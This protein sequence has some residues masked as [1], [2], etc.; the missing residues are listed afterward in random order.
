[1]DCLDID[2]GYRQGL[3][4]AFYIKAV[5]HEKIKFFDKYNR[6]TA[7]NPEEL[8]FL[9]IYAFF[10]TFK[11]FMNSQYSIFSLKPHYCKIELEF[12]SRS[13]INEDRFTALI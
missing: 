7:R 13:S 11:A 10:E 6:K 12:N 2:I 5:L 8:D 1:M 9:P 3:L 4:Q